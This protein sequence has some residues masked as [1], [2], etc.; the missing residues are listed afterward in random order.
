MDREDYRERDRLDR[1]SWTYYRTR[2]TELL[3]SPP[4]KVLDI[5]IGDASDSRTFSNQGYELTFMD[6]KYKRLNKSDVRE[7]DKA[8]ANLEKLPFAN[9]SFDGIW[10]ANV[11]IFA[12]N[13]HARRDIIKRCYKILKPGG[14]IFMSDNFFPSLIGDEER[15]RLSEGELHSSYEMKQMFLEAGFEI[16]EENAGVDIP[17]KVKYADS[18][19]D[20][21]FHILFAKR[22]TS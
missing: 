16:Q 6:I 21:G 1:V 2:F 18:A 22:P 4:K 9:E 10:M 15:E 7:F 5:G 8:Q 12:K 3:G 13:E 14:V 20:R 19:G 17:E 11:I